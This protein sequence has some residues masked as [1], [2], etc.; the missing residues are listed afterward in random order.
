MKRHHF[1]HADLAKLEAAILANGGSVR[2]AA[3][4]MYGSMPT[5]FK[6]LR[7]DLPTADPYESVD[8]EF[9]EVPDEEML[10]SLDFPFRTNTDIKT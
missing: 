8:V 3:H 1:V 5:R 6:L 9:D 10:R 4:T 2:F 7:T